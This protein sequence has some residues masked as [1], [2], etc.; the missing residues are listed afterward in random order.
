MTDTQMLRD[1]LAELKKVNKNLELL[2]SGVDQVERAVY[3][4]GPSE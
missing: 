3:E 4:T 2:V 1:I